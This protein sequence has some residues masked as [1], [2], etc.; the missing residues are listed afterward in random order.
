MRRSTPGASTRDARGRRTPALRPPAPRDRLRA[1]PT[2]RPGCGPGRRARAAHGRGCPA[3]RCCDR[4]GRA[5]RGH[6]RR[7]DRRRGRRLRAP[8]RRAG[9]APH[10]IS[11]PVRADARV[12]RSRRCTPSSTDAM[13][14]TSGRVPRRR[15]IEGGR[16]GPRGAPCGWHVHR[17]GGSRGGHRRG[18]PHGLAERAGLEVSGGV[19]VDPLFRTTP[20]GVWA[21]GDIALMRHPILDRDV[22]LDHWAAAWF[23]GPAAARSMLG[24]VRLMSGSRTSTATS[25]TCRWRHGACHPAGTGWSSEASRPAAVPGV[26]AARRAHRG[27][28]A[29]WPR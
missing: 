12:R 4:P 16:S 27:D 5:D 28:D 2:R 1:A 26:L 20:Q 3:H 14:W 29:G 19:R 6:R 10:G 17:R 7:L 25:T 21:V 13:G 8:T 9:D 11:A 22:R 18:A 23:G 24:R 15:A